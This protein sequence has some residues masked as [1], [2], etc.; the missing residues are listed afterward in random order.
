[1]KLNIFDGKFV[2]ISY[3]IALHLKKQVGAQIF[4]YYSLWHPLSLSYKV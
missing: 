2:Y 4:L 1:M 3:A